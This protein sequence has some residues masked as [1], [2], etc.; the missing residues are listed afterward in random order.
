[1][2][3]LRSIHVVRKEPEKAVKWVTMGAE[4]GLPVAMFELGCHI[5]QGY[6][7]VPD[8]P[9]AA[10]W[11]RRA[12]DAGHGGAANNLCHMYTLGRGWALRIMIDVILLI[13]DPRLL[14]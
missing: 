6:G 3:A 11:Y 4:A 9:A 12:A 1:M 10:E 5:D 13:V 8:Y 7:V 14:N 2:N